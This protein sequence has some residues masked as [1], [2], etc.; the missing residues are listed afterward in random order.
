MTIEE[1]RN[2]LDIICKEQESCYDCHLINFSKDCNFKSFSDEDIEKSYNLVSDIKIVLIEENNHLKNENTEL[3]RLL[4]LAVEDIEKMSDYLCDN[5]YDDGWCPCANDDGNGNYFCKWKH[6]D[7][8][9]KLIGG[10]E[11]E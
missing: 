2:V 4:K 6:I 5:C 11:N 8:A 10:N 7:E 3:K 9:M 1:K